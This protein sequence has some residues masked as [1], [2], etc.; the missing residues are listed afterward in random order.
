MAHTEGTVTLE[1][2]KQNLTQQ[3]EALVAISR[4]IRALYYVQPVGFMRLLGAN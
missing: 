2:H 3:H 1:Y 4:S